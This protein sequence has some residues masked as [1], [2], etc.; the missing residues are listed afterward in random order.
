MPQDKD[1]KRIVRERMARTGERYT[2]VRAA[3]VGETSAISPF[4]HVSDWLTMLGSV[5]NGFYALDRLKELSPDDRRGVALAGI[6]DQNWR[7]RR[8]CCRLLDDLA[9]TEESMAA[10]QERLHD[11]HPEVRRAALHTLSCEHCKPDDSCALDVRGVFERMARDPNQ[12]VRKMIVGP[13][14]WGFHESWA[15][16]LL[17]R[18]AAEDP[19][20]KLRELAEKGISRFSTE[21]EAD[22]ARRC[23]PEQ[24]RQK[25][26]RHPLK[27]VAVADGNIIAANRFRGSIRRALKGMNRPDAAVYWVVPDN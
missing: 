24:L 11:E 20:A 17:R 9:L 15:L 4:D 13:L 8:S 16:D 21:L 7:V 22:Q 3:L 18:I 14:S 26:E 19:S 2:A 5:D 23:L 12:R 1:F 27:W 6:K 25:T 10:L